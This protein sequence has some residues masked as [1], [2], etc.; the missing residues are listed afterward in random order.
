MFHFFQVLL[1]A[2]LTIISLG[3]AAYF[4]LAFYAVQRLIGHSETATRE[5][6]PNPPLSLLKPLCGLEP[7]LESNLRSFFEQDYP[8]YEILFAVHRENDPA[9]PLARR[10]MEAYP[11]ISSQLLIIPNS[12]YANAKIY[13]LEKLA[14]AARHEVLIITDSDVSVDAGYLK[15]MA[16]AFSNEKAGAATSLYRGIGGADLWSKLEALGMSTEFMAGVVVAE[17]LEGMKFTLGPSMG[18]TR[19]CLHRIGG[20]PALA[21]Y[22]ADDF[23]LGE[24]A[25]AAGFQVVLTAHAVEHHAYSTGFLKSFKHRLRWNRSSRFSRPAGYWGQGFTYGL[26]WAVLLFLCSPAFW[27]LILFSITLLLR[28]G[29][30]VVLGSR[31]L[32][33][34]MVKRRMFLIPFQDFLSLTA[35]FGGL[36]GKE[37]VWRDQ[38]YQLLPGGRM[39]PIA[40]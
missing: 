30:A 15:S 10:L 6:Q 34:S 3:G 32:A 11:G 19:T 38:R 21:E 9:V 27:T 31:L 33:D 17:F 36:I 14:E 28:L 20:F 8:E 7:N 39:K 12:P 24:K 4:L 13:S 5:T 2:I 26:P 16:I 1:T 29:L 23:I 37:I 22:L 35:W 25:A 40:E 18:I